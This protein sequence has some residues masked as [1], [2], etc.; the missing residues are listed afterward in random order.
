MWV[1]GVSCPP[2]Q[3]GSPCG[4]RGSIAVADATL[5]TVEEPGLEIRVSWVSVPT[6]HL[7]RRFAAST[8]WERFPQVLP[9][10]MCYPPVHREGGRSFTFQ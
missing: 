1:V 4:G 10:C 9:D 7:T 2:H 5:A 8:A 6:F 3:P